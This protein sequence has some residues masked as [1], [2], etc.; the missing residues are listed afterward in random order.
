MSHSILTVRNLSAGL[1][2]EPHGI[3]PASDGDEVVFRTMSMENSFP[4]Q[5]AL[6]DQLIYSLWQKTGQTCQGTHFLWVKQAEAVDQRGALAEPDHM[7]IIPIRFREFLQAV[8]TVQSLNSGLEIVDPR[9][10]IPRWMPGIA[11]IGIQEKPAWR[12]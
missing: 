10:A 2:Q 9:P 7:Y 4:C 11:S 6:P 1:F 3:A 5:W 12:D 8:E